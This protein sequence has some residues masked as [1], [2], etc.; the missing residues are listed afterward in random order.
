MHRRSILAGTIALCLLGSLA[1]QAQ[2]FDSSVATGVSGSGSTNLPASSQPAS[3]TI[4]RLIKF[5]GTVKDSTGKVPNGVVGST[6]SLF[7][8]T[9]GGTSLWT[10]TQSL[11]LDSQGRYTRSI[12]TEKQRPVVLLVPW[13]DLGFM[14]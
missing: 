7:V 4:P 2:Q 6:F 8:Q 14:I 12:K 11:Q 3:G 5:A 13:S 10:E 1:S 9:E